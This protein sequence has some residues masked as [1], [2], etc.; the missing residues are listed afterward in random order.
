[1]DEHADTRKGGIRFELSAWHTFHTYK[2]NDVMWTQKYKSGGH[3]SI[4]IRAV[5]KI[6]LQN[7]R[8]CINN[9]P[10][11]V[12]ASDLRINSPGLSRLYL[13]IDEESK[14]VFYLAPNR[15]AQT[16]PGPN[17]SHPSWRASALMQN[18]GLRRFSPNFF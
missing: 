3:S 15:R 5:H 12:R 14:V 6:S 1:M 10:T 18:N 16:E 9:S 13:Q 11:R 2:K 17:L 7:K 4:R 8:L